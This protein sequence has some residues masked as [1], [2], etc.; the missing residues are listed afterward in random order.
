MNYHAIPVY[1]RH[2]VR[3]DFPAI[4][5][6][7]SASMPEPWSEVELSTFL[8]QQ[9]AIGIV[10][11]AETSQGTQVVGYALYVM[12]VREIELIAVAVT[13]SFRRASIGRQLIAYIEGKLRPGKR[14][15]ILADVSE[16]LT[17]AHLFLRGCHF[18]ATGVQRRMFGTD[19]GYRFGLKMAVA[20]EESI[21]GAIL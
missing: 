4:L 9:S 8:R 20:A 12:H 2:S 3:R 19:D 7:E 6:I 13:S 11:E 14:E 18:T 15:T 1:V 10:A 5:A 21:H 17:E 16:R